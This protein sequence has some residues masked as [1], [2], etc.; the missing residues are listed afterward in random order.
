[1]ALFVIFLGIIPGLVLIAFLTYYIKH[2]VLHIRS[3]SSAPTYVK[4][5]LS[6]SFQHVVSACRGGSLFSN[7]IPTVSQNIPNNVN[8]RNLEIKPTGL[9]ST[10]NTDVIIRSNTITNTNT[11][12]GGFRRLSLR[13]IKGLKLNTNLR[14]NRSSHCE[15]P[16]T[17]E[18]IC[19]SPNLV[20][21]V[22]DLA[23]KFNETSKT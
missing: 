22:K 8:I 21:S 4:T 20:V 7:P 5:C 2:N 1:M 19:D 3:K 15:T 17:T 9:I 11:E 18:T 16:A 6:N 23:K 12:S 13:N 10:T 14:W